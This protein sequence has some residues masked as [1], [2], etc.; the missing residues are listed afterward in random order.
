MIIKQKGGV[1]LN[2]ASPVAYN[3]NFGQTNYVANKTGAIRM[4]KVWER[5]L[6]KSNIRVN[7]IAPGFTKT[8]MTVEIPGKIIRIMGDKV[9]LKRWGQPEDVAKVYTFLA[10][11][12]A[13]Y[14]TRTVINVDEGI[15][16]KRSFSK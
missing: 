9:P 16:V 2:Y 1:I 15:V 5:E 11:N 3:E 12:I 13:I 6:G 8:D 7:T 10:R 4:T 14:T